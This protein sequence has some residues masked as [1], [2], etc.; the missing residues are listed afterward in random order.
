M[1]AASAANRAT[2]APATANVNTQNRVVLLRA[3]GGVCKPGAGWGYDR[4]SIWWRNCRRPSPTAMATTGAAAGNQSAL[5]RA[6]HWPVIGGVAVAAGWSRCSRART[7]NRTIRRQRARRPPIRRGR[8]RRC[9]VISAG[10]FGG[11]PVVADLPVRSVAADRG[12]R[13]HAAAAR[14]DHQHRAGQKAAGGSRRS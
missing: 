6:E 2:A 11:A 3:N 10:A 9:R 1:Q 13:R 8:R 12:D 14:P 7:R 4:R 5:T